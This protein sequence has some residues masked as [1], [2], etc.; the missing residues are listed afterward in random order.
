MLS[1]TTRTLLRAK[2]V[3]TI[4]VTMTAR[5]V[6][7]AEFKAKCLAILDEVAE[8]NGEF[9]V[10]K[11]G[12]PVARVVPVRKDTPVDLSQSVLFEG[13]VLSPTGVWPEFPGTPPQ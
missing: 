1:R 7:A 10:T 5:V 12:K 4:L 6:S 3:V 9:V 11:R 2:G 8:T 13:D